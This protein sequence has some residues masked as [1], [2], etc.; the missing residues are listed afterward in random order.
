MTLAPP[1]DALQQ[2]DS[3]HNEGMSG[4][5][6]RFFAFTQ[7][8]SGTVVVGSCTRGMSR[9]V[10]GGKTWTPIDALAEVSENAFAMAPD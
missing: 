9:S 4:G 8:P 1:G 3:Q 2:S 6:P 7:L 5:P 10:D